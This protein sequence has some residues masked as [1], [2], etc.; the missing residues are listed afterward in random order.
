M[1]IAAQIMGGLIGAT[2]V[3]T[4]LKESEFERINPMP[5][6]THCEYFDW[7]YQYNETIDDEVTIYDCRYDVVPTEVEVC[8]DEGNN[9]EMQPAPEDAEAVS[10]P[11]RHWKTF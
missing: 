3:A 2:A 1:Y 6:A 11:N 8:D 4:L 7:T 5:T 9:C 10:N